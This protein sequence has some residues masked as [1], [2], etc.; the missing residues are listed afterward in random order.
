MVAKNKA[1]QC[2]HT[3]TLRIETRRG[4]TSKKNQMASDGGA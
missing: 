3:H 1:Q 2:T 4:K